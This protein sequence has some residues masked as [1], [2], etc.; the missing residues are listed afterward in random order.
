MV[1]RYANTEL[2]LSRIFLMNRKFEININRKFSRIYIGFS[3][4]AD[5]TPHLIAM[6]K[7]VGNAEFTIE[8]VHFEHGIRGKAG[9]D[10]AEW[11]RQFCESRNIPFRQIDL[12][13]EKNCSNLEA[14]ARD[15]R[16]EAWSD[17]AAGENEAVALGQHADDRIEN[18]FLRMMRGSNATGLTSLR[19]SQKIKDITFIRP[20]INLRRSEIEAFLHRSGVTEWCTDHTN[21]EC[22]Y[23]RNAV[24]NKLLPMLRNEFPE[25][26]KAIIKSISALETDALF[27][28]QSAGDIY[29]KMISNYPETDRKSVDLAFFAEMHEAM[30]PRVLRLWLSAILATDTVPTYDFIRRFNAALANFADKR[31][32]VPFNGKISLLIEKRTI[33]IEDDHNFNRGQCSVEWNLK[34]EPEVRWKDLIFSV[35]EIKEVDNA[36]LL[37]R[38]CCNVYF[39]S[40]SLP[41]KVIIRSRLEG[42]RMVPFGG[43]SSIKVKKLLQGADMT[44]NEKREIPVLTTQE[45]TIIWIPGV[46]RANFANIQNSKTGI[47][48]LSVKSTK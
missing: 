3:G 12:H 9:R 30:R 33:S 43:K 24:R 31:T 47:L 27:L 7:A 5:S 23:R 28:E 36:E 8:A 41:D 4:G 48:N 38:K 13:M 10:D 16:L 19:S 34:Q 37:S 46:R 44:L 32:I 1:R 15:L 42:D 26:D 21:S 17:I 35:S 14:A 20:L 22:L 11:C 29:R 2:S 25:C 40:A 18:L 45:G 39:D 6:Q